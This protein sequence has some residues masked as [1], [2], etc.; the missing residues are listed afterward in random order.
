[1]NIE[2][3]HRE[4]LGF[5]LNRLKKNPR[6]P[7]EMAEI[8]CA[9]GG[10]AK[11]VLAQWNGDK[12]WMVDPW[13]LQDVELYKENQ[14]TQEQYDLQLAQC[15]ELAARDPR[16]GIV[17][18]NSV[19]A[20]QQ[21]KSGQLICA[22]IDANHSYRN[23]ME[24]MDAWWDKVAAGGIMG[25]HDY[26]T[27]TDEG[28]FCEVDAAVNRWTKEHNVSFTVTPCTSWWIVKP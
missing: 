17:R 10:F 4:A 15:E 14:P 21:F 22:Y 19:E 25:G 23:C 11:T 24:D 8:G 5:W 9:C 12:Y 26:R 1:M 16:V 2:I 28:W 27:K 20:A 6:Q 7:I 3:N 13:K 18:S